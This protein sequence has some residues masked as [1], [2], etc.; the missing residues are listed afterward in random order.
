[1][2]LLQSLCSRESAIGVYR[3]LYALV[4]RFD[5]TPTLQPNSGFLLALPTV[6]GGGSVLTSELFACDLPSRFDAGG[7]GLCR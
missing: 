4:V 2:Q 3:A 6:G 5:S 7:S 1:M